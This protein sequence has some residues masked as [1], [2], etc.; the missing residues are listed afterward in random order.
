[1]RVGDEGGKLTQYFCPECGATVYYTMDQL[2]GFYGI[3]V[4]NFA[5][6][7]FPAP[8]VAVYVDRRHPWAVMPEPRLDEE[9]P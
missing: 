1:V 3:P 7:T 8:K 2:P 6:N 5:D 4:G 9:Y